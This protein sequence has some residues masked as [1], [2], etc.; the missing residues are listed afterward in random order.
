MSY[1]D[2]EEE[3]VLAMSQ[4]IDDVPVMNISSSSDDSDGSDDSDE[5]TGVDF[6]SIFD[7]KYY[8]FLNFTYITEQGHS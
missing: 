1:S 5:A 3:L 4:F 7:G 8:F 2:S 6:G